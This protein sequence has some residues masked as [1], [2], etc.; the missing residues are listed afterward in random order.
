MKN[1]EINEKQLEQANGGFKFP[2]G[3]AI[4]LEKKQPEKNLPID[5]LPVDK[6]PINPNIPHLAEAKKF[7]SVASDAHLAGGQI[8]AKAPIL[9]Y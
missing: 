7:G 2:D 8:L 6:M 5:T 1:N 3:D 4:V 9:N